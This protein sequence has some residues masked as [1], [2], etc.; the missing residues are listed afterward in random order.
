MKVYPPETAIFLHQKMMDEYTEA[1]AVDMLA[2]LGQTFKGEVKKMLS[3]IMTGATSVIYGNH[4]SD[5][6]TESATTSSDQIPL[7]AETMKRAGANSRRRVSSKI[8][9]NTRRRFHKAMVLDEQVTGEAGPT[10]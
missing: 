2:F 3:D 6:T 1:Y 9:N 7:M 5:A 10:R 4:T 8:A